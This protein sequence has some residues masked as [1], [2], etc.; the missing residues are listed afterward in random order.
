M[1]FRKY[2]ILRSNYFFCLFCFRIRHILCLFMSPLSFI[3]SFFFVLSELWEDME[4]AAFSADAV[5]DNAMS[6]LWTFL[7]RIEQNQKKCDINERSWHTSRKRLRNW[8]Q[9][10]YDFALT[11]SG[12]GTMKRGRHRTINIFTCIARN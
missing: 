9:E 11:E 5:K 7:F 12:S 1:L 3:I 6:R 4:F 8:P 2:L 10:F